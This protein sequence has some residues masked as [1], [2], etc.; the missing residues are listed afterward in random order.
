M[1]GGAAARS[2]I[3]PAHGRR[4]ARVIG[5]HPALRPVVSFG[6]LALVWLALSGVFP[7]RLFPPL[8][9]V[10]GSATA[11]VA[12]GILPVYLQESLR[13]LAVASVMGVAVAVPVGILLGVSQRMGSFFLPL[14]S[15]FA[16]LSGIAWLPMM[17]VWFGFG[18]RTIV[19]AINYTVVFPVLYGTLVG[20]R[21]VPGV[22]VSAILT[23]GGSRWAVVRDV[24]L[25]GAL[26]NVIT[27]IRLGIAYGW[28]AL[29]AAEMVVGANGLGF[30]IFNGQ[31]VGDLSSVVVGM[32]VIGSLWLAIDRLILRPLEVA[33]IERWGLMRT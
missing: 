6:F 30:M 4:L 32:L 9:S 2:V 23:M 8:A 24:L 13:H 15:F 17:L 16:S 12:K 26:P 28:R 11:Q 1:S 7:E 18:E 33:T 14:V 21:T 19:A 3:L 27:G 22:F 5:L 10:V 25:P 29:I 31:A 20:V